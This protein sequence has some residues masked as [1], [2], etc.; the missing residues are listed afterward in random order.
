M[1]LREL[2]RYNGYIVPTFWGEVN[3]IFFKK[4][5]SDPSEI[6]SK[7]SLNAWVALDYW[8]KKGERKLGNV[9]TLYNN[10]SKQ[11]FFYVFGEPC[12]IYNNMP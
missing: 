5:N 12:P 2:Q 6:V 7:L 11:K 4:Y 10:I 8:K 1:L 3:N 9:K